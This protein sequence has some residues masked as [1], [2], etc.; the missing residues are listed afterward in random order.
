MFNY[1]SNLQEDQPLHQERAILESMA[2]CT[3]EEWLT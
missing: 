2:V 1:Q 3:M